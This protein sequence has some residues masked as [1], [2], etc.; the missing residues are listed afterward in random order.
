MNPTIEQQ[1]I[2][3]LAKTGNNIAIQATAGAAKTTTCMLIAEELDKPS[4]YV[5]YN[6]SIAEEAGTKFP[7]HVDCRT[8]HSIAYRAIVSPSK[9]YKR[10]NSF[11]FD[12]RDV[13]NVCKELATV[14]SKL[15]NVFINKVIETVS[16]Y[17]TSEFNS[18]ELYMLSFEKKPEN[19][20]K[21]MV[22]TFWE[23][24]IDE[25][26]DVKM[27]PN[28]YLKLFQLYKPILDYKVIYFDEF[29]DAS[30]VILDIILKQDCQKIVVG[31][32]N[33]AIYGFNNCVNGFKVLDESY[34]HLNLSQS[35]RFNSKIA[36]IANKLV[37][38]Y[39]KPDFE[40]K[41]LNTS[42]EIKSRAVLAR[43]N[44]DIFSVLMENVN[45]GKKTYVV[46]GLK[47]MFT[48]LYSANTLKFN[49]AREK[50]YDKFIQTY[51]TW[52]EFVKDREDVAEIKKILNILE[53]Y[54]QVHQ[55]ITAIKSIL[56]D[57]MDD[58]DVIVATGH[59]AKGLEFDEVTVLPGYVREKDLDLLYS[60]EISLKELLEEDQKGNLMFVALTRAKVK[61]NLSEE[62]YTILNWS[63]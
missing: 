38:K 10:K 6:K 41:G 12:R 22:V 44:L 9:G 61:V 13:L 50:I 43:T 40:I 60:G 56:V 27:T 51:K 37:S 59:K 33:Q 62:I 34:T 15:R 24:V 54:P 63:G 16:N 36:D 26:N 53:T 39:N 42:S 28:V 11:F 57:D 21:N 47:D 3:D 29:Q 58:A 25:T 49:G 45:L 20:I 18:I 8:M 32:M 46:G 35:F 2:I 19:F 4:L 55:T 31:D 48:L 1:T 5:A 14:E 7:S 52:D 17:C 30:P 23:A